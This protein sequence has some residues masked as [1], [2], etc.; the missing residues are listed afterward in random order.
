MRWTK[1]PQPEPPLGRASGV[2]LHPTSL[3]G[4]EGIGTLGPEA[5][6]FVDWLAAAGQRIWQV[7]PLGPPGWHGSPYSAYSSFAGNPLLI[8]TSVLCDE[9]LLET[10]ERVTSAGDTVDLDQVAANKVPALRRACERLLQDPDRVAMLERFRADEAAWLD[11]WALF[12]ALHERHRNWWLEWPDKLL[13]RD[14]AALRSARQ[15]LAAEITFHS[16]MQFFFH[17]QWLRLRDYAHSRAVT[18]VGDL[19]FYA[20]TDSADVWANPEIFRLDRSTRRP[21]FVGGVP[22]D[23]FSDTGQLWGMPVY[24]WRRLR[25]QGF[26]WW[27]QRFAQLTRWV[28]VARIDHFRGFQAFWRVPADQQN[29]VAGKWIK[30]PG[31]ALFRR[32]RRELGALPVWTEDLGHIT[33]AV[34]RL[35][36]AFGMPSMRVLQFG[37]GGDSCNGHL[38][39][40]HPRNSV[41]YTGTHD[42]DT[43]HGWWASLDSTTQ[44]RVAG[45]FD[46]F[47]PVEV[48]WHLVRMA[49]GSVAQW[50]V[51]PLQDLLGLG[52][53]ARMNHPGQASGH[54]SWRCREAD[55]N[56]TIGERLRDLTELYGRGG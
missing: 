45:Y 49:L 26:R 37:L 13:R 27:V 33:P 25:R 5:F 18:L 50:C 39:F 31:R 40:H 36:E 14:P 3:P 23:A 56:A 46:G 44:R 32:L 48:H 41:V 30:A 7:L 51:L 22:P 8:S 35:R 2:L 55:L 4:P 54:W 43:A 53:S 21:L 10:R 47:D 15:E 38:P 52:S 9:G 11:D 20:A 28:D 1:R 12:A 16:C 19:S 42:N 24:N 29:A 6:G 17:Q 34:D